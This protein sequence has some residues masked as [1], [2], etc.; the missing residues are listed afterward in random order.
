MEK[1]KHN[2]IKALSVI[3]VICV[4]AIT[5]I[6]LTAVF[7]PDAKRETLLISV[8]TISCIQIISVILMFVKMMYENR[9]FSALHDR[10]DDIGYIRYNQDKRVAFIYGDV[11]LLTGAEVDGDEISEQA[12]VKLKGDIYSRKHE[13]EE[14]IYVSFTNENWYKLSSFTQNNIECIIIRDVT[15]Y[16][17]QTNLIN[18][19]RYYDSG[20]GIF[21]KDMFITKLSRLVKSD[22]ST[23]GFIHFSIKG[24]EKLTSFT[25][26]TYIEKAITKIAVAIK[27]YCNPHNTFTGRTANNEITVVISDTN[28]KKLSQSAIEMHRSV[29][30]AMNEIPEDVT[31]HLKVYCGYAVFNHSESEMEAMLEAV[32]FATFDAAQKR[33]DEPAEY[34][35]ETYA[36]NINEFKK[37]QV[38]NK[39]VDN[40]LIDYHFQ[41]IV[42]A[43]TGEIYGYEA[44]M[45]PRETDGTRLSPF[46]IL[47]IAQNQN[48]LERIEN[49]TMFNTLKHLSEKQD[50]FRERRLFVNSISCVTLTV[51]EYEALLRNY[52]ELFS[53]LVI[54]ITESSQLADNMLD[55]VSKYFRQHK[56][57]V[58]LDDYGAGYSNEATLLAVMPDYIK[59]DRSLM[60]GIDTDPQKQ[61]LV[62]NIIN[63]ASTHDVMVL[64]EGVETD[65]ELETV[66][67]LGVDLIQG[68][69]LCKPVPMFLL[70][71]AEEKKNLIVEYR[72]KHAKRDDSV[73]EVTNDKPIDIVHL[74]VF[75]YTDII[76]QNN[77][78]NFVGDAKTPVEMRIRCPDGTTASLRFKNVNITPGPNDLNAPLEIGKNCTIDLHLEGENTLNRQGIRVPATSTFVLLGDGNLNI[79]CAFST[80]VCLGSNCEQSYGQISIDC[81]GTINLEAKCDKSI[82]I[83]GG[84]GNENSFVKINSGKI[85][86][87]SRGEDAVGIGSHNGI[88]A[89][90]LHN[91]TLE[92]EVSGQKVACIG[93][94]Y[95]DVN[96]NSEA[97]IFLTS[98][99]D[100]CVLVG[101][102]EGAGG[103]I[104]FNKGQVKLRGSA[105]SVVAIGSTGSENTD[106]SLVSGIYDINIEGSSAICVGD[107]AGAGSIRF[108]NIILSA[109]SRSGNP[110]NIIL[111]E[112]KVVINS[113]NIYTSSIVPIQAYSP[114]G[115]ELVLNKTEGKYEAVIEDNGGIYRYSADVNELFE[116]NYVYLPAKQ[117]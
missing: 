66:I 21:N 14:D 52:G 44:L 116:G 79:L 33:S 26:S 46:D 87:C 69:V 39:I 68:Y 17:E 41:P 98:A 74:A 25:A 102:L 77:I 115:S 111:K 108:D 12:Y 72:M 35:A 84:I 112:G 55:I 61:Q 54:E 67:F 88:S 15:E 99:G 3:C 9:F 48:M 109:I 65:A 23:V 51:S 80:G 34:S 83:G 56:A 71:I 43:R 81:S 101:S 73:Y 58:A 110:S 2:R 64:A 75:G 85:I 105:K 37:L 28:K 13:L 40:N 78:A 10:L 95:G 104:R 30:C 42:S 5:I 22:V 62:A 107:A 47:N 91:C 86:F 16:I 29:L 97:D 96:I 45:R 59:V 117:V 19:L 7:Y 36:D 50:V 49:A 89:I 82:C 106:I 18:N 93:S 60:Q 53:K 103:K 90:Y 63:F 100:S 32:E 113:G 94:L 38:F 70:D 57:H 20:T 27:S 6:S 114:F 31:Q 1:I 24:V 76:V 92:G 4:V 8:I 11:T